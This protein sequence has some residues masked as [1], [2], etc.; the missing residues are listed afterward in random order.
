MVLLAGLGGLL[1]R[2]G[3]GVDIPIGSPVA[4]RLDERL[5]DLVGFFVNTLVMR[6]DTSGDPTFTELLHRVRGTALTAYAH[7]DVPFEHLVEELNPTRT[8]A[9]HPLFQ[10]ML[11]LQ[12]TPDPHF[13]LPGLDL[14]VQPVST[15]TSR[16]DLALS[17]WER[18]DGATPSGMDGVVEFSLDLFDRAVVTELVDRWLRIL[19]ALAAGDVG[20]RLSQWDVVS[21]AE[22]ADL[23]RWGDGGD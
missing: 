4:G 15:G 17:L 23:L 9:H 12:N 8:L 6:V 16:F 13:A 20:A 11:A 22:R 1:S 19:A 14:Q 18:H 10:I 2:L 7:Q 5:D 3:A 21:A